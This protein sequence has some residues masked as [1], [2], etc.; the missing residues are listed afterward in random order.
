MIDMDEPIIEFKNLTMC[1]SCVRW[2]YGFRRTMLHF[3]NYVRDRKSGTLLNT[4]DDVTIS[5]KKD[6]RAGIVGPN[7]VG[8]TTNLSVIGWCVGLQWCAQCSRKGFDDAGAEYRFQR[9]AF[10]HIILQG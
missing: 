6:K 4:L 1:F 8:K 5:I 9:S 10:K 2:R 3:F 7:G